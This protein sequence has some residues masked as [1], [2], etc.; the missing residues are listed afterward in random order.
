VPS[1]VDDQ[2]YF[3]PL[4]KFIGRL[5]LGRI[6]AADVEAELRAQY[7]RFVEL[8]GH[9]PAVVNSHHH[10]QVFPLVGAVLQDLL[11]RQRQRPYLRRVRE[12][13]RMLLRIPGARAKRAFLNWWGRGDARRQRRAGFPGNDWLAG[14]TDPPCVA[15]PDFLARWLRHI[16][17]RVV[18][19]TCHP[20]YLDRTLVGRDCTLHDGHLQRRVHELQL[21]QGANFK[22]ACRAAGFTLAAPSALRKRPTYELSHAA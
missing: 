16:P 1:L 14:V 3:R 4:G 22:E 11:Q 2:G 13:W 12:P 19:L 17:G 5:S 20:G 7:W 18:E 8:V 15:D 9:P 6:R 21:L 10:V